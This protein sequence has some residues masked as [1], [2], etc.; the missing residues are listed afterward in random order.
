MAVFSEH[1]ELGLEQGDDGCLFEVLR[2]V[3][4]G[5]AIE[6]DDAR[7]GAIPRGAV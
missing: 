6:V 2:A 5:V 3:Q 7:V 4:G 1:P